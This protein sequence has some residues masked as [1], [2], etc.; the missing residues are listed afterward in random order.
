MHLHIYKILTQS[1]NINKRKEK[2]G[3][4]AKLKIFKANT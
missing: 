2:E 4:S 1:K 3:E